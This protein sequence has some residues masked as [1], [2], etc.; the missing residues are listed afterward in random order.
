MALAWLMNMGFAAGGTVTPTPTPDAAQTPAG[1]RRRQYVEID[2]QQFEV[3]GIEEARQLLQR[4]RAIAE[5]QAE[6]KSVRV[7]KKLKRKAVVPKVRVDAPVIRVAPELRADLRPLIDDIQRLYTQA[8]ELAE[9]RLL[10][11]KVQQDEDDEDDL[12]LL[13]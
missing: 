1:R 3:S 12:L 13:L 11:L 8:A 4:A 7:E 10:M 2:G 5:R 9:L 6:Q